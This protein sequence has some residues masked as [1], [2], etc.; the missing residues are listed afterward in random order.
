[1]A[2][3]A[4]IKLLF[5]LWQAAVP[6]WVVVNIGYNLA[7]NGE[8]AGAAEINRQVKRARASNLK[9]HRTDRTVPTKLSKHRNVIT[10]PILNSVLH[11][12]SGK[13]RERNRT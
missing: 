5:G 2:S 11:S 10:A 9:E 3:I 8:P 1:M 6:H 7:Q 4:G 12:E 13:N